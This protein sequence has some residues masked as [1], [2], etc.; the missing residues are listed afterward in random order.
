[1]AGPLLPEA[2]DWVEAFLECLFTHV[3]RASKWPDCV[4]RGGTI[5]V[6]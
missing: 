5:W 6:E 4:S 1:M 2:L 3:S